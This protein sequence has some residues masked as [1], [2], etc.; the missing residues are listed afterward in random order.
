MADKAM[1]DQAK[2]EIKRTLDSL[3]II[4]TMI[5][6]RTEEHEAGASTEDDINFMHRLFAVTEAWN[7]SAVVHPTKPPG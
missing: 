3:P 7:A 2:I 5:G 6:T 1:L 4:A